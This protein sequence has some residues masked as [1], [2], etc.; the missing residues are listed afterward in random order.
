MRSH[1]RSS[2]A[3]LAGLLVAA[4]AALG[5][6]LTVA[7]PAGAS[8]VVP[9]GCGQPSLASSG[10]KISLRC[11]SGHGG[12]Y[13]ITASACDSH[14]CVSLG[15]N[16]VRYGSTASISSGGYFT[17]SSVRV[18]WYPAS[19][20]SACAYTHKA[21]TVPWCDMRQSI[22][23]WVSRHPVYNGAAPS[24]WYRDNTYRADC[25]GFVSM[26]WHLSGSPNTDQLMSSTYSR[27][28]AR[29]DLRPGDILDDVQHAWANHHVEIFEGWN[30]GHHAGTTDGTFRV[31][32]FGYGTLAD[33]GG[34]HVLNGSFKAG[35]ELR[36]K[37]IGDY[38]P[39]RYVHGAP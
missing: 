21:G 14:H 7:P 22:L 25:S 35:S 6:T 3:G 20:G 30:S 26:A 13:E 27:A 4:L 39:R 15:S 5:A 29:K 38:S 31:W 36:G 10:Q 1:L 16:V 11:T 23:D 34:H 32:S 18:Y 37:P 2:S 33:D 17:T 12:R 24:N 28:V 9:P 19:G 8:V